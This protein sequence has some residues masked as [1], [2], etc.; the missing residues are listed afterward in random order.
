MVKPVKFSIADTM[1][2]ITEPIAGGKTVTLKKNSSIRI[3]TSQF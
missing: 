3:R 2:I 1:P